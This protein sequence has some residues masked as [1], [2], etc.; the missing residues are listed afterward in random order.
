MGFFKKINKVF[1][2]SESFNLMERTDVDLQ[3]E[4]KIKTVGIDKFATSKY[5][6]LYL[7]VNELGGFLILETIIVSAT[8]LKS[9]KGSSLTFS[10]ENG[11]LKLAS[12]ENKI[13]SDFSNAVKK[14]VTK[15]DYNITTEEAEY[16]KEPTY[17][18]VRFKIN[19]NEILFSV[20][21]V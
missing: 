21:T 9:K 11:T 20:I 13:E 1:E 7:R 17:N 12:D 18:E 6:D 3:I 15:I 16:F 5:G 2:S 10:N 19:G 8:D 14:S 4:E